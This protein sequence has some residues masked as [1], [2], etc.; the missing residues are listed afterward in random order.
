V[1][2]LI[3][4]IKLPVCKLDNDTPVTNGVNEPEQVDSIHEYKLKGPVVP[5]IDVNVIVTGIGILFYL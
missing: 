2:P 4:G 5:D 1:L 3:S